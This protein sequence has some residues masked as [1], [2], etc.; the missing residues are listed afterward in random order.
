MGAAPLAGLIELVGALGAGGL[1]FGAAFSAGFI[2]LARAGAAFVF[3]ARQVCFDGG[4]IF[5]FY[6]RLLRDD[7][8]FIGGFWPTAAN[9]PSAI[10]G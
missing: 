1:V 7:F 4:L 3:E 8:K 9:R 10:P 5:L 2:G 6:F